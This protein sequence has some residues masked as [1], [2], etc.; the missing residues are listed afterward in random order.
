MHSGHLLPWGSFAP[1]QR[2]INL[3]RGERSRI[4]RCCST[5]Q[6]RIV[7]RQQA[8]QR[9][10]ANGY[11]EHIVNKYMNTSSDQRRR[12][13]SHG[14]GGKPI[15]YL[16]MPYLG[17]RQ[18]RVVRRELTSITQVNI[19]PIF[20]TPPTLARQLAPRNT[21]QCGVPCICDG[22]NLCLL[23][24]VVYMI[25]CHLCESTYI[26]ETHRTLRSRIREHLTQKSSFVWLHFDQLHKRRPN[27]MDI[28][29]KVLDANFA[30][31]Y[32]RKASEAHYI[33]SLHPD[34]NKM[35]N[36]Q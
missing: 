25:A 36:C 3:I 2:K 6:G 28:S 4:D 9:F 24:N 13:A 5:T 33:H 15:I 19:R 32:Q 27:S 18:A 11:P 10:R 8:I 29:V 23:K 16:R 22:K 31:T 35:L 7:S 26:G 20:I 17:E 12:R 14:C 1:I 21:L 30:D 34:I